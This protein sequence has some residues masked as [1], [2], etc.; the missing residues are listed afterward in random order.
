MVGDVDVPCLVGRLCPLALLAGD[1][2][3]EA[4][5]ALENPRVRLEFDARTGDWIGLTDLHN[6]AR[7]VAGGRA[8]LVPPRRRV[9]RPRAFPS[10][11]RRRGKPRPRRRMALHA[12]VAGPRAGERSPGGQHRGLAWEATPVPGREGAGTIGS[13]P[14]RGLLVWRGFDGPRDRPDEEMALLIGAIDDF[15]VVY[16]NGARIGRTGQ[17]TPHHWESPRLYRFPARLLRKGEPNVLMLKVTNGSGEGGIAGPVVLGPAASL[18]PAVRDEAATGAFRHVRGREGDAAT[19][20]LSA[21]GD[22]YEY[23]VEWALIDDSP[24]F[25]RRLTVTTRCVRSIRLSTISM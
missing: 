9:A 20:T 16:L 17:D 15:D 8:T 18:A 24:R 3:A 7:L 5:L 12:Q 14:R 13:G 19:L 10:G 11:Q 23:R 6:G 21:E 1:G 4:P 22:G 25:R 2:P